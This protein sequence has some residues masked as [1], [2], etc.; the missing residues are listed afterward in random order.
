MNLDVMDLLWRGV[1]GLDDG[2][3]A[4]LP[5]CHLHVI[6]GVVREAQEEIV[7][8]TAGGPGGG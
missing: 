3:H 6:D 7:S 1:S 8:D 2:S 4:Q 5:V